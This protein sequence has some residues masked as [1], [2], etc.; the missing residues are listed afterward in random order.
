MIFD[1]TFL[2]LLADPGASVP[3]DPKTGEVVTH[4]KLRVEYL[5]SELH[6]S[7]ERVGI[8]TPAL[9]EILVG[10]KGSIGS[11]MAELTASYKLR[12]LPFEELAAVEVALMADEDKLAGKG[13]ND[14][15][16]AKVKYDRQIIA[17]AKVAC[18]DAIYSDDLGLRK[19]AEFW[20]KP[21]CT[22]FPQL[23]HHSF[24]RRS[25]AVREEFRGS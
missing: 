23:S 24:Q 6:K 2:M 12:T 9:A 20:G 15:T 17:I 8:P 13:L 25:I 1:A 4:G 7:D 11:L 3:T 16:K 10:A 18:A 21:T 14:A 22:S 19:K 5:L